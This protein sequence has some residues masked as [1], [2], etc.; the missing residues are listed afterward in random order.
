MTANW[1][2]KAVGFI[3]PKTGLSRI[4]ARAAMDVAL[5]YEGGNRGRRTA[6]WFAPGTSANA[7]IGP[8]LPYLRAR[9]RD[10]V[11][12]NPYIKKALRVLVA[13]T[14]GKGI[15][16]EADTGDKALDAK[17]DAAFEV[18]NRECDADGQLKLWDTATRRA[19]HTA[20][21]A[22]LACMSSCFPA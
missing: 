7:E 17:I 6:N 21:Y 9:S 18:W 15:I 10:L 4:R 11:R 13:N 2:D 14:V 19:V 3:S 5:R 8:D 22:P 16:P 1:I 20:R 12:N